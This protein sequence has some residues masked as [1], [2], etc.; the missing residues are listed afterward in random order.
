MTFPFC[1]S[2]DVSETITSASRVNFVSFAA[3]CACLAYPR[4]YNKPATLKANI[5]HRKKICA[6]RF[7][8]RDSASFARR[9]LSEGRGVSADAPEAP[10]RCFTAMG[11]AGCGRQ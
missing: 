5:T 7:T 11:A 9:L 4:A 2:A 3:I 10:L 1:M 8:E 6:T